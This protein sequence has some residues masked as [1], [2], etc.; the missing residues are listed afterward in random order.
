MAEPEVDVEP[1][2]DDFVNFDDDD[3]SCGDLA[4]ES[5]G[6]ESEVTAASPAPP[7][8]SPS[9]RPSPRVRAPIPA[10]ATPLPP[11]L[12]ALPAAG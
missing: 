3:D 7:F 2:L 5:S 8:P 9:P 6:D 11:L 10:P 12:P 4:D 1:D